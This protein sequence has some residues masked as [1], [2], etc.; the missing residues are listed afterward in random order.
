[1]PS[2]AE[3]AKAYLAPDPASKDSVDHGG[4]R[5]LWRGLGSTHAD[6]ALMH[7]IKQGHQVLVCI[8]LPSQPEAAAQSNAFY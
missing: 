5:Q 4:L 6:V 8:L 2:L 1:M 7:C 3:A